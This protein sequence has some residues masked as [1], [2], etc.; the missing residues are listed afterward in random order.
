MPQ[1]LGHNLEGFSEGQILHIYLPQNNLHWHSLFLA[2]L[3][4]LLIGNLPPISTTRSEADAGT[5]LELF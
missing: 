2:E 5:G 1:R 4:A 3:G